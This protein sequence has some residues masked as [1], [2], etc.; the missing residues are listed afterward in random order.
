MSKWKKPLGITVAVVIVLLLILI[1]TPFLINADAF[2][3]QIEQALS[4]MLGRKVQIGHLHVSLLQGSLVANQISI[5]DD[6]AFSANPFLTARSLSVGVDLMPLIFSHRLNV[7]SFTFDDPRIQLLRNASGDWNF[8]TLGG[9]GAAPGPPQNGSALAGVSIEQLA[10]RNGTIAFG[11]A[12]QPTRLAYDK[13]NVTASNISAAHP[14]PMQ[15]NANTPG[16]G[17]LRLDAKVGPLAS[18]SAEH[19]PFQ[20]QLHGNN[21]PA[22]DVQNLLA[23]LGY[24]LPHGSSLQGGTI[25]ANL[26]LNGPLDNFVTSGPVQLSNV[27]LAGFSLPSQLAAALGKPGASTGNDTLIQVASS[28]LRYSPAGV[29]A[30]ALKVIIPALGTL[31][32]SGTVGANNS[33]NFHLVAQLAGSSPLGQLVKLPLFS[34]S[35]GGLPF[36]VTGTTSHPVVVPD[37]N[38]KGTAGNILQRLAGSSK[39]QQQGGIGGVIGGFLGK[40]KSP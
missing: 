11:R 7:R 17:S 18:V 16:G 36:H 10:V 35:G 26:N 39:Q 27:R 21:V 4:Q 40:K 1:A 38:V 25:Q 34:Q 22:A 29:R 5:A 33:L 28:N 23:V 14:F 12:G 15:F 8:A 9:K 19:L 37:I 3:P 32:G 13:V 20:G 24:S 2:R 31:T 6:P 30:D